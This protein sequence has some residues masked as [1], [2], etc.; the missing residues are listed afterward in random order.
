MPIPIPY[1]L[2]PTPLNKGFTLLEMVITV[3]IMAILVTA[4]IVNFT[5]FN[6]KKQVETSVEGVKAFIKVAQRKAQAQDTPHECV[7]LSGYVN[8]LQAY[9]VTSAGNNRLNMQA[10]CG[11]RDQLNLPGQL[12]GEVSTYV[13]PSGVT[14]DTTFDMRF[15]VL[16][17]GAENIGGR[18]ITISKN[19]F[20]YTFS[21]L[22]TGEVTEGNWIE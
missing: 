5:R 13:L 18:D 22:D 6:E 17:G 7:V 11:E 20:E 1:P 12:F 19:D 15:F 3:A 9:R 10:N 21:V 2:A 4:T 8:P 16:Y 14:L